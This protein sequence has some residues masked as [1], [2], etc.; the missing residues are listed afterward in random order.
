MMTFSFQTC[1]SQAIKCLDSLV[2]DHHRPSPD[3]VAP[4]TLREPKQHPDSR[5][6]ELASHQP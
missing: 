1:S 6:L 2:N 5:H 4:S 3:V